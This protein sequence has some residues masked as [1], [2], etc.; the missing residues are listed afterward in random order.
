MVRDDFPFE[1]ELVRDASTFFSS[2]TCTITKTG[3]IDGFLNGIGQGSTNPAVVFVDSVIVLLFSSHP[4]IFSDTL[5]FI[6]ECLI[7]CSLSNQLAMVSAQLIPRILS[8]PRLQHLSVV[9][10]NNLLQD[11]I[12]ITEVCVWLASSDILQS[13]LTYCNFCP[14]SVRNTSLLSKVEHDMAVQSVLWLIF[15]NFAQKWKNGGPRTVRR[16]RILLRTLETEGFGD[17]LEQTLL[18][19]NSPRIGA[20]MTLDIKRTLS[21]KSLISLDVQMTSHADPSMLPTHSAL[22]FWDSDLG[23]F[24]FLDLHSHLWH[25]AHYL[26]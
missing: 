8:A 19:H 15:D 23:V 4:S 18:C 5:T 24:V 17:A 9:E 3:S 25:H 1:K 21:H 26:Y 6:R 2:I 13:L 10:D 12:S 11:F 7:R 20:T 22:I 14:Q 16:G